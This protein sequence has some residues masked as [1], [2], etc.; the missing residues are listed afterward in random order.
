[1]LWMYKHMVLSRRYEEALAEAYLEGKQP[2][3]N[4]ANGPL[5]GE[6]HLSNGQEPVRSGFVRICWIT[7]SLQPPIG[8]TIS[9][10]PKA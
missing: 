7:T 6:M 9:Q 2:L 1:M 5:P 10:L 3:F 4:M 8:H